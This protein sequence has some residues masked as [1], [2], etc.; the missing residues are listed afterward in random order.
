[1][2]FYSKVYW[3]EK[4]NGSIHFAI[5]LSQKPFWTTPTF[6][7]GN[8]SP[9]IQKIVGYYTMSMM[10]FYSKV[11]WYEKSN[12]IIHFAIW[13]SQ[14]PLSTTPTFDRGNFSPKIQNIVGYYTMSMVV[15]YSKVYWYEKSN[16]IIHFAKKETSISSYSGLRI[17]SA[18]HTVTATTLWT[19][20]YR[21]IFELIVLSEH[22]TGTVTALWTPYLSSWS[23]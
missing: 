4:S 5:S 15:F 3:Y 6:D 14:K 16:A 2:V 19:H 9:K 20:I 13:L 12:A 23:Y 7:R 8:F 1:M 10:V 21:Y 17:L 22:Y 11:C 18:S